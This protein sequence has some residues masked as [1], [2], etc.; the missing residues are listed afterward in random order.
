MKTT[1][2]KRDEFIAKGSEIEKDLLD[3]FRKDDPIVI[4]DIGACDGLSSIIYAKLFPNSF[5]HAFEPRKDNC[6]LMAKNFLECDVLNRSEIH[7]CALGNTNGMHKFYSS[8]G[9]AQNVTGWDTGNKS[10]SL[11]KPK[12]HKKIHHWCHFKEEKCIVERLDDM[13][14]DR[15]DFVHMDVQG[16]ELMVLQGGERTLTT[17]KAMWIEAANIELYEG[18]PMAIDIVKWLCDRGFVPA[19]KSGAFNLFGDILFER[20]Q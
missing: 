11:L 3:I 20:K 2:Q 16:A 18:Q 5:I 14:V 13:H 10:S 6:S 9:Q 15:L 17:A 8:Y 19:K 7:F 1:R 4:A 12:Q